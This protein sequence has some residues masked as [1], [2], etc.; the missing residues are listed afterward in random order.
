MSL[1]EAKLV[2][3]VYRRF[4]DGEEN[5][6]WDEIDDQLYHLD[7]LEDDQIHKEA[8]VQL[9]KH[10]KG[11]IRCGQEFCNQGCYAIK[12]VEAVV[13][14]INLYKETEYLPKE[15]R[16]ILE[17]YLALSHLKMIISEPN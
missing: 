9:E 8:D 5:A 14:I 13:S 11:N 10:K 16:Y 3:E 6:D 2:Q 7:Y 1:D 4:L 12:V 17:Y 15:N